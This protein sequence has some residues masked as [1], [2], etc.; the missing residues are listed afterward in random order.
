MRM[1]EIKIPV[2][3]A[4]RALLYNLQVELYYAVP[5]AASRIILRLT[6]VKL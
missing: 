2:A 5:Y 3:A 1:T 4:Y 6:T